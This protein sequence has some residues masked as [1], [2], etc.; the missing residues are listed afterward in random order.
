MNTIVVRVSYLSY[1]S[2]PWHFE[3]DEVQADLSDDTGTCFRNRT[4]TRL[5]QGILQ[6]KILVLSI[7]TP[8]TP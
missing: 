5:L 7:F 4:G 2:S 3:M 8:W 6:G 1:L